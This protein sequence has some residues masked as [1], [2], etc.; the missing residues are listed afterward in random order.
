M[1]Q[2][3]I[4]E[5]K[6]LLRYCSLEVSVRPPWSSWST[7]WK[8][9]RLC[10][11]PHAHFWCFSSMSGFFPQQPIKQRIT[12]VMF[13]LMLF[14]LLLLLLLLFW[15]CLLLLLLFCSNLRWILVI[16]SNSPDKESANI[17]SVLNCFC[18]ILGTRT[19]QFYLSGDSYK[20]VLFS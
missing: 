19:C 18:C 12:L 7:C 6:T 2:I 4:F 8:K 11:S 9:Q 5:R 3:Q 13:V 16:F 15:C 10:R 20:K 1:Y 17:I 14:L